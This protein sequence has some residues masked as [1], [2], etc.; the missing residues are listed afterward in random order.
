MK[1]TVKCLLL[2]LAVMLIA[3]AC[4]PAAPAATPTPLPPPQEMTLATTTSTADSGLLEAILPV[5]EKA[6]NAKVKVVAVGTGQALKLGQDGNADVVLVHARAQEDK[7]VADGWGVDRRDVMYNDFII[8]GPTQDQ[9]G[10]KGMTM[11]AA[12]LQAIANRQATF[13]SRGDN[14]GTHS[15][16]KE[17]WKQA[18]LEP[19]GDWYKS[20]GQGM[21]DTLIF[22]NEKGAYTLADRGTYLS[23]K[24]KLPNLSV[25]VGGASIKENSDQSLLNPYG[26]IAVNPARYPSVKFALAQKFSA[27]LTSV[28]TQKLIGQYGVAR[29]GQPLFYPD[30]AEYKASV[31]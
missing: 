26:V 1:F 5:F 29:F 11:A 21:G 8:V 30:S 19:K 25:L 13:A 3:S 22:A 14:S 18:G 28:E 15:K 20:L 2:G 24:D 12:A 7:F 17:L 23:M 10:L 9:A 6:N 31:K 4:G 16:E 27:W